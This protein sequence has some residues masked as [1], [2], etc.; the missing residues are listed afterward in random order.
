MANVLCFVFLEL[1]GG[2]FCV[3]NAVKIVMFA[4]SSG[5]ASD[6]FLLGLS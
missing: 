4:V 2:S 6:F 1:D 5:T 3:C